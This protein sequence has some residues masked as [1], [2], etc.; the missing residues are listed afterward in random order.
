MSWAV[1]VVLVCLSLW[2][3]SGK[4]LV[5]AETQT[6]TLCVNGQLVSDNASSCLCYP[7]W[8]GPLCSISI[9]KGRLWL[10]QLAR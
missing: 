2:L 8:S 5:V 4:E 7:G 1:G 3:G 6:V 9:C 10:V